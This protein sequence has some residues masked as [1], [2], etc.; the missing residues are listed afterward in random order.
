MIKEKINS[1]GVAMGKAKNAV[2]GAAI[3]AE[4]AINSALTQVM[5]TSS[6]GGSLNGLKVQSVTVKTDVKADVIVSR[7]V[8]LLCAAIAMAGILSLI[9]GYSD[10]TAAKKDE[11]AAGQSKAASK[12][13]ISII[14]IA[15][16]AVVGFIFGS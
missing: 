14:E 16:P 10:Y 12:M 15:A 1:L 4:F 13:A 9:N 6:G 3:G 11:N 5:C 8:A 7:I 2:V